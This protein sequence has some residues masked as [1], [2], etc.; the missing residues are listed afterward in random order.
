MAGDKYHRDAPA[1]NIEPLLQLEPSHLGHLYIEQQA[2]A[3]P[4]VVIFQKRARRWKRFHR[5]PGRAQHKSQPLPDGG[6]IVDDEDG[7]SASAPASAPAVGRSKKKIAPEGA[8]RAMRRLPPCN[9]TIEWLIE[10]PIPMPSGLVVTKGSKIVSITSSAIPGPESATEISTACLP[11]RRALTAID[12]H[13]V[14]APSIASIAFLRRFTSTCSIWIRSAKTAGRPGSIVA[15]IS[16]FCCIAS[17][18]VRLTAASIRGSTLV[19]ARRYSPPRT[20][21]RRRSR[22]SPA[23]SACCTTSVRP[24]FN[25]AGSGTGP[26]SNRRQPRT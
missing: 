15:S 12:L 13:S 1:A 22:T 24:S 7:H 11:L 20:N 2:A 17:V 26:A 8:L 10:S 3:S 9:S 14:F 16:T 21:S 18:R 23:R 4:R 5:I 19:R 6:V 25:S